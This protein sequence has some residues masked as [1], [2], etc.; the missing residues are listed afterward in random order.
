MKTQKAQYFER[1]R[2]ISM[3]HVVSVFILML[4]AWPVLAQNDEDES[5]QAVPGLDLFDE[6]VEDTRKGWPQLYVS[7]GLMYLDADGIY[8][9]RLPN[10][11]DVIIIDFDRAGLK[12]TDYSYWLSVN[13]RSPNSR[14]GAWFGSW[15]YNVSGSRIW[16]D[17]LELPDGTEIPVG[18]SVNSDFDARWYIL[19]ATYSFYRSE[20]VDT[21]IG[22]GIHA[23]D[24]DTTFTGHAQI[25]D[26]EIEN[27]SGNLDTLAPLPN[28]L[29][30]V[31]WKFA[32][33]WMLTARVGYF[34]LDYDKYSGDMINAHC[35]VSYSISPRWAL[36]AGY[37]FVDLD[38]AIEKTDY[39][40]VYDVEFAGPMAYARFRF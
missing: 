20:T 6:D 7:A 10:G 28:V 25:G 15:R 13:W 18:A 34:T 38:L 23:V 19:E 30:Y 31:S 37:Q 24:L 16:Q 8:S 33:R 1:F 32:P 2:A 26:Q 11:N 35:M 4:F 36:G 17:S 14:W 22:L 3:A 12:E 21:G 40:E 39:I 27:I 9:A 29:A 5:T